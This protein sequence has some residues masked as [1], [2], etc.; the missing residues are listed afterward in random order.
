MVNA[1]CSNTTRDSLRIT[2]KPVHDWLLGEFETF[3]RHKSLERAILQ[4]ADLLEKGEYGPVEAKIKN[5]VQIGLQKDLGT[6]YWKD[7]KERL[8]AIKSNN[9]QVTTGWESLDRKLFGGSQ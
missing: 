1:A 3:T 9:G 4:S 7:P 2:R 8:L 6:D 5:A